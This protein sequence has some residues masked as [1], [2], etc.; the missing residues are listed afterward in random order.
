MATFNRQQAGREA[1]RLACQF[2]QAKGMR[3]LVQNYYCY[4]GEIDLIMQDQDDIVFVEVRSRRRIDY[5]TALE[6]INHKKIKKLQKTAC[7]FLQ[8]KQWLYQVNSRFDVVALH[9]IAGKMRLEWVKNA[10]SVEI[11]QS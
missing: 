2:L 3:L 1:E 5:G 10:F 11:E 4:H 9:P 7:H 8:M 6:S